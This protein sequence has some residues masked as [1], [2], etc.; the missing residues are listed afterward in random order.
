MNKK[1]PIVVRE[2]AMPLIKQ[3]GENVVYIGKKDIWMI[4][5]YKFPEETLTGYPFV[6]L[7]DTQEDSVVV[8][9]GFDALQLLE[10]FI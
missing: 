9:D 5:M 3:Y 8:I 10:E 4:Y 6:Y 2:K 7:Y 1:V